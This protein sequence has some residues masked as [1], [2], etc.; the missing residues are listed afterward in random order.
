MAIVV[1]PE[2]LS[3]FCS[4]RE[5]H[6][7]PHSAA[8]E[9]AAGSRED[10]ALGECAEESFS[11]AVRRGIVHDNCLSG[12]AGVKV[13]KVTQQ[14]KRSPF[15][16]VNGHHNAEI[17]WEKLLQRIHDS[18]S[19]IKKIAIINAYDFRNLGDQAIIKA[20]IAWC[21][22]HFKGAEIW[23]CS[24]HHESNR[25]AYTNSAPNPLHNPPEAKPW[26]R[27]ARPFL[28]FMGWLVGVG[29]GGRK[30][31]FFK[32]CDA[33]FVCGGGYMYSSRAWP[34]SRNMWLACL[35]VCLVLRDGARVL[36]FPQSYGPITK[37]LDAWMVR[38][39][40]R[41]LPQVV[42][43]GSSSM[44][45]LAAL[46]IRDK[47]VEVADVV[48]GIRVLCSGWIVQKDQRTGLGIIPCD[49][50]FVAKASNEG[51]SSSVV[52][53]AGLA[54][55]YQQATGEIVRLFT[56]V[57]IPGMDDDAVIVRM[58][59]KELTSRHVRHEVVPWTSDVTQQL[60]ALANCRLVVGGRMHGCI[61]SL[62]LGI[63]TVGL[64]Y[65][66]KFKEMFSH[67]G[68]SAWCSDVVG[69]D[70]E[71]LW[72]LLR[73]AMEEGGREIVTAAVDRAAARVVAELDRIMRVQWEESG[74]VTGVDAISLP[75][76]T[77]VTPSYKQL[78]WL[79]LC[80][81]SVRDQVAE[82]EQIKIQVP[83][84]KESENQ[85]PEFRNPKLVILV[86]HLIQDAE[87]PHFAE[88]LASVPAAPAPGYAL[89]VFQESDSG[90]YDA[91]N[92]GFRRATGD[93]LAWLNCD[94]QYL[95]GALARVA[96]FFADHPEVDVL[97]GDAL[98]IDNHARLLSYRRT[99]LPRA[100]H[101][102]L[103][104]LN[105]LSCA[106]FVRRRVLERGLFL[107]TSWK[108]IADAVWVAEMLRQGLRMAVLPEPLAAFTLTD[109]N[110]GQSSLGLKEAARW[111]EQAGNGRTWMKGPV[112]LRHRLEKLV[113]GAYW[114]RRC[115][116]AL[117]TLDSP[118]RRQE[119]TTEA[120]SFRWPGR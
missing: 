68:L 78:P 14:L 89:R 39:L 49:Y 60:Q 98:L 9:K 77:I 96:A 107:D 2:K 50:R 94:E 88:F 106:T 10:G 47:V 71:R 8:P 104:H 82:S 115:A 81:A 40:A 27:L 65:Q 23:V 13:C 38:F 116:T 87:S 100:K 118:G 52:A 110:L 97:F 79:R 6:A 55:R 75:S 57:C 113:A 76:F 63:P 92:R 61:F 108:A 74:G 95:P 91:I 90:M 80:V 70:E 56:Q 45:C 28:D 86:E 85:E 67:L 12:K 42:A 72:I 66:P 46:G 59:E 114:P 119:R 21:N 120:I 69:V 58:L 7:P 83:L 84:S 15:G 37:R 62:S 34:L 26:I 44:D 99:V 54:V 53:L 43:R 48:L 109:K 117:Y 35:N 102:R 33:V 73:R 111:A 41:Q 101:I 25:L 1:E 32:T 105:T 31:H 3:C 64:A 29:E 11:R 93:L 22:R 19:R 103:S 112:V 30:R 20:Q 4:K 16:I 17:V 5:L 24:N 51:L 18:M 36:A